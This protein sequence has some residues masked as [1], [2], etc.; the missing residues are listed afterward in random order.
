MMASTLVRPR[1]S[2]PDLARYAGWSPGVYGLRGGRL[3]V[4]FR[5]SAGFLP[6]NAAVIIG[7]NRVSPFSRQGY[8]GEY[9][10]NTPSTGRE[11]GA[12]EI[13]FPSLTSRKFAV[14]LAGLAP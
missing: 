4:M 9:F 7:L 6:P 14:T 11:G 5:F 1:Q 10:A 2:G 3:T 13:R 8:S 12:S